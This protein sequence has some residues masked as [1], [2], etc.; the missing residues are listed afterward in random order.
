VESIL[1]VKNLRKNYKDDILENYGLVKGGK[2]L[3][4]DDIKK[5]FIG[6]KVNSFGFEGL[7]DNKNEMKRLF[8]NKAIIDKPTLEDVMLFY[9]RRDFN[10]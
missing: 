5:R 4:N 1:E 2:E 10:V 6:I 3:L 7:T 9:T 8:G